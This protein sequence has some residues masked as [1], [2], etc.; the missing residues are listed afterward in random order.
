MRKKLINKI[1]KQIMAIEQEHPVRVGIDGGSATGKTKFAKELA[2]IIEEMGGSV[3]CSSI[4]GFHNPAEIRQQQGEF[5]ATGYYE[6]SFNLSAVI[7]HVLIP[8]GPDGTRLFKPAIFDYKQESQVEVKEQQVYSDS[9][10]I[11]EGVFLFRKEL[12]PFWDFRIFIDAGFKVILERALQRDLEYF[13]SEEQLLKKYQQ[14]YIPGQ[15]YYRKL[16]N[17]RDKADL[18]V[19]NNNF[20]E[21]KIVSFSLYVSLNLL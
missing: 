10:L 7:S 17:P 4:D 3:V 19:D 15:Q 21:P 13:G 18:V 8:L 11:M 14:R 5:S 2:L 12:N 1:A 6:D 16:E 20:V 9:I